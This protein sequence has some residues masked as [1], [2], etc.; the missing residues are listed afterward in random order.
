MPVITNKEK[1][2]T[3]KEA[4]KSGDEE[5]QQQAALLMEEAV[6][7]INRQIFRL[8]EGMTNNSS[9]RLVE[10]IV[11]ISMLSLTRILTNGVPKTG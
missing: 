11:S 8:P 7:I 2:T 3:F 1:D 9:Q 5:M 6:E 10:C 4:S